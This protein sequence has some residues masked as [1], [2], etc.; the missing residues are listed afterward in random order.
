MFTRGIEPTQILTYGTIPN[1]TELDTVTFWRCKT[2]VSYQIRT[3]F[4]DVAAQKVL[5]AFGLYGLVLLFYQL[6]ICLSSFP[7]CNLLVVLKTVKLR[8]Y[9]GTRRRRPTRTCTHAVHILH[10]SIVQ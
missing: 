2:T 7:W 5:P 8:S 9:V 3:L 6:P 4:L 1:T 10:C